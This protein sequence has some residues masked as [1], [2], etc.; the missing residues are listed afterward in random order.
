MLTVCVLVCLTLLM[1]LYAVWMRSLLLERQQARA[2]EDRVQ[3]EYLAHS[4]LA[5][6]A[7]RLDSDA[8]YQG[9]TWHARPAAGE[10]SPVGTVEIKVEP[11]EGQAH[12]RLVSVDARYPAEDA[13]TARSRQSKT[14]VI[15]TRGATP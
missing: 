4:A 3:A 8:A 10:R 2:E 11:V 1:T 12:A 13:A 5:R 14:L 9:E 7:A 15:H 6:A